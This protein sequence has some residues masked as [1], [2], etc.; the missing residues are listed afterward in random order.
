MNPEDSA[1]PNPEDKV[2][3]V[4]KIR[5]NPVGKGRIWLDGVEIKSTRSIKFEASVDNLTLVTVEIY[6]SVDLET[7]VLKENL[8]IVGGEPVESA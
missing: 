2:F 1:W 4:I 5:M 8:H 7:G 6:G 3:P